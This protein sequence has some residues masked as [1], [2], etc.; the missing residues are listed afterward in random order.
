MSSSVGKQ[1]PIEGDQPNLHHVWEDG[2]MMGGQ[3]EP[4]EG[5]N[6]GG[7]GSVAS[8]QEQKQQHQKVSV[9][10]SRTMKEWTKESR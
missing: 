3:T 9:L 1:Q 8:T 5:G 2:W 7:G 6:G 10:P 4:G